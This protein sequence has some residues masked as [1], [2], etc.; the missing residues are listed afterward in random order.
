M[1]GQEFLIA[2]ALDI[3]G[4]QNLEPHIAY[5]RKRLEGI[6]VLSPKSMQNFGASAERAARSVQTTDRAIRA[7]ATSLQEFGDKAGIALRRFSAFTIAAG[8]TFGAGRLFVGGLRDA[9][10]FQREMVKVQQVSNASVGTIKA[11]ESEISRLGRS[12]A[13]P[14]DELLRVSVT[15]SQA[16]LS[17][18]QTKTALE[19]LSRTRLAAT[20]GSIEN[21]A[22]GVI[23]IMGQFKIKVDDI[24]QSLAITNSAAAKFAVE[25]E[26]IIA[27]VRR[28]GG[29]FSVASEGI[30]DGNIA[31]AKFISLF[32]S[33]RQTT[34]QAPETIATGLRTIIARLQ[35]P[36]NIDFFKNLGISLRDSQ[37]RFIGVYNAIQNIGRA[38][39]QIDP[40]SATF[41]EAVEKIGGNRQYGVVVPLIREWALQQKIL[42]ESL[43]GAKGFIEETNKPL[44]TLVERFNVLSNIFSEFSRHVLESSTFQVLA[45]EALQ[46]A[47]AI[48]KVADSIAPLIPLFAA[49]GAAKIGTAIAREGVINVVKNR[50]L[51]G[52]PAAGVGLSGY[53]TGGRV[54]GFG[55]G[56]TELILAQP[57][58]YVLRKNAAKKLGPDVLKRLNNVDRFA[59]GG[60][61][62]KYAAGGV[63]GSQLFRDDSEQFLKEGADLGASLE[64]LTSIVNKIGRTFS[65]VEEA[66]IAYQEYLTKLK[67]KPVKSNLQGGGTNSGNLGI[68]ADRTNSIVEQARI[69]R[70]VESNAAANRAALSASNY[71]EQ[72]RST[73]D[74]AGAG[75][76]IPT[77]RYEFTRRRGAD[78]PLLPNYEQLETITRVQAIKKQKNR[79]RILAQRAVNSDN[80]YLDYE[81][82][83]PIDRPTGPIPTRTSRRYSVLGPVPDKYYN[84]QV[85][86]DAQRRIKPK[87]SVR[88]DFATQ[89]AII[90][91]LPALTEQTSGTFRTTRLTAEYLKNIPA[92]G[93]GVIERFGQDAFA[94]PG[95]IGK[96]GANAIGRGYSGIKSG[97][98][99]FK[100]VT[101]NPFSLGLAAA[102]AEYVGAPKFV[103]GALG[104]A[105]LGATLGPYGALAGGLAGGALATV[106]EKSNKELEDINKKLAD[107]SRDLNKAFQDLS[108]GGIANLSQLINNRFDLQAQKRRVE[109]KGFI[110]KV[111]ESSLAPGAGTIIGGGGAASALALGGI[112]TSATL[113]TIGATAGVG[114]LIPY[115]LYQGAKAIKNGINGDFS[116]SLFGVGNKVYEAGLQET[117]DTASFRTQAEGN[118][119]FAQSARQQIEQLK[120]SGRAKDITDEQLLASVSDNVDSLKGINAVRD[121]SARTGKKASYGGV[122]ADARRQAGVDDAGLAALEKAKLIPDKIYAQFDDFVSRLTKASASL[123]LFST[124]IDKSSNDISNVVNQA[125]GNFSIN[126]SQTNA[127]DNIEALSQKQISSAIGDLERFSGT[128]FGPDVK[129]VATSVPLLTNFTENINK[130]LKRTGL[131]PTGSSISSILSDKKGAFAG[132]SPKIAGQVSDLFEGFD[133]Q[134]V[135]EVLES[136]SSEIAKKI[137]DITGGTVDVLKRGQDAANKIRKDILE[138]PA[139]ARSQ[140]L[141]RGAEYNSQINDVGIE[142]T[143]FLAGVQGKDLTPESIIKRRLGSIGALSEGITDPNQ[144]GARIQQLQRRGDLLN[145]GV[146]PDSGRQLAVDEQARLQSDNNAQLASSTQALGKL[147]QS[148]IGLSE[149]QNRLAQ[150]QQK[151][152]TIE[153]DIIS[154]IGGGNVRDRFKSNQA[155]QIIEGGGNYRDLSSR[156]LSPEDLQRGIRSKQRELETFGSE[157][158]KRKFTES[159]IPRVN[160]LNKSVGFTDVALANKRGGAFAANIA[161]RGELE[162]AA[163]QAFK[164][165]EDAIKTQQELLKSNIDT[166]DKTIQNKFLTGVDTLKTIFEKLNIPEQI[167][168]TATHEHHL[169]VSVPEIT[170]IADSRIQEIS[171]QVVNKALSKLTEGQQNKTTAIGATA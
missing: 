115:G 128:K 88:P 117:R 15:L 85:D 100:N 122:L 25:S 51:T 76:N 30:D 54:G 139:N 98:G 123:E 143:Q 45:T 107:S 161:R 134:K 4:V 72:R 41:A 156:G 120:K 34:R 165:Q 11:L 108:K 164:T 78:A 6:Q 140:L 126:S 3:R 169:V 29:A 141:V 112:S 104:G 44:N 97:I 61:I 154:D 79:E 66:N 31:L 93:P 132:L 18:N 40:L 69:R 53:N 64:K 2:G 60:M 73:I 138:G 133:D 153:D 155:L 50:L 101:A 74:S 118:V 145:Q 86:F 35:R 166:L 36:E 163:G 149:I 111:G 106:N 65:S 167:T 71:T 96:F 77:G 13:A 46:F 171:E 52:H 89:K 75:L 144:L 16:G 116:D 119:D 9:A 130:E 58:E 114:A 162:G 92:A 91:S 160:E 22:E 90:P 47:S 20:F 95:K 135:R 32:S 103:S 43:Q 84:D 152:Q 23:A 24:Q 136:D 27:A 137:K 57:G 12:L 105:A 148:A 87:I 102:G 147:A 159:F 157:E 80:K 39:Q 113:G 127:F 8:A 70:R 1:A 142:R 37:G 125:N 124:E 5:I 17:A 94:A 42:N 62:K 150:V 99:R 10:N 121:E 129:N 14:A 151:N 168:V 56:D 59:N 170:S 158:D 26:D 48:V 33:V 7:S 67:N 68:V 109:G 21:T 38:F 63:V 19:A 82:E 49:L 55:S 83:P 131:D 81:I 110:Q 28:A 146:D